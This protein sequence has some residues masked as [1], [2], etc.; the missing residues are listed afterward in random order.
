MLQWN[1]KVNVRVIVIYPSQK[2]YP[3]N[4]KHIIWIL[5]FQTSQI[6]NIFYT[7]HLSKTKIKC[8]IIIQSE[9]TCNF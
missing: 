5:L 2:I 1:V 8:D 7:I 6:W 4:I 9:M 3:H